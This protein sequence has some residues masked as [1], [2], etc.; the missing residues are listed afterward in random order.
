MF[1]PVQYDGL[2]IKIDVVNIRNYPWH[3]HK[4]PQLIY[5]LRGEI[6]LKHVFTH[7]RLQK[8][9]I[10]IIHRDDIHGMKGSA[11]IIW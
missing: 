8:D 2:P 10:H 4:D 5:V 6:E 1:I 3:I 9:D 7:Y 11:T